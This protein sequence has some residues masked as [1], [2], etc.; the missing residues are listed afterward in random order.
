MLEEIFKIWENGCKVCAH[1]FDHLKVIWKNTSTTALYRI[2]TRIKIF[3]YLV[4]GCHEK[5]SSSYR[6]YH[7]T[8]KPM[9]VHTDSLL[10][11]AV[12]KNVLGFFREWFVV[13][14]SC[15]NFSLCCQMAPLHSIKFQ[16]ADFPIYFARIIVIFWTTCIWYGSFL[17]L[18]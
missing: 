10:S 17:L 7:G 6:W 8:V 14:H 4:T 9:F 1:H 2:C 13:V 11:R 12:F 3:H 18:W 15:S 16:T 5:L